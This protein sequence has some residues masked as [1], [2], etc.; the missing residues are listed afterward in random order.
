MSGDK[1][2]GVP[3]P[4]TEVKVVDLET[5]EDLPPGKVGELVG[6]GPQVMKGYWKKPEETKNV[7][8]DG[9]LFTGDIGYMD[10]N[11]LF[12]FIDRKKDLINVAGFMIWPDEVENVLYE[13]PAVKEA[14]VVSSPDAEKGEVPKAFVVLLDGFEGKINED[15]LINFCKER[16]APFKAPRKVEFVDDLPKTP[17]GKILRRVLREKE[18]QR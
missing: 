6:R 18:W 16:L 15:E 14:A 7:L 11:G 1:L 8:K 13:H 3:V 9:W 17:V 12:Y 5:G 4:D 2:I 10:E